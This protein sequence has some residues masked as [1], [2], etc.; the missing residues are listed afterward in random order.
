MTELAAPNNKNASKDLELPYTG[1]YLTGLKL[2]LDAA[3]LRHIPLNRL[4]YMVRAS[5]EMSTPEDPD[6]PRKATQE[7]INKFLGR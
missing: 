5:V 1:L 7:D 3:T 2:G 4:I 6:A